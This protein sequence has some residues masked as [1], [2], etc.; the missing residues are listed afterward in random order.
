[1]LSLF[2]NPAK[3]EALQQPQPPRV[4]NP[5]RAAESSNL[6]FPLA[7]QPLHSGSILSITPRYW[8]FPLCSFRPE[9]IP[10]SQ[11]SSNKLASLFGKGRQQKGVEKE[12]EG[13]V[14]KQTT[15]EPVSVYLRFVL[16]ADHRALAK[17]RSQTQVLLL[18]E[19]G[20]SCLWPGKQAVKL[21]IPE[22]ATR[23]LSENLSLVM[24]VFQQGLDAKKDTMFA[25]GVVHH[26]MEHLQKAK[27]PR[28]LVLPM[29]STS[30]LIGNSNRSTTSKRMRNNDDQEIRFEA[31]IRLAYLPFAP[32][33][34]CRITDV[35]RETNKRISDKAKHGGLGKKVVNE[36]IAEKKAE[37]KN[38]RVEKVDDDKTDEGSFPLKTSPGTESEGLIG[39][40]QQWQ[41][42]EQEEEEE[43]EEEEAYE[44][45][46]KEGASVSSTSLNPHLDLAASLMEQI[47]QEQMSD[48]P[49]V[50]MPEEEVVR[51]LEQ[52]EEYNFVEAPARVE[53][54][55]PGFRT[56]LFELAL[57]AKMVAHSKAATSTEHGHGGR[58]TA[59]AVLREKRPGEK[60]Q[61]PVVEERRRR[62]L[63]S[64][65]A[66][67]RR[68]ARLARINKL[69]A[70]LE[71][72]PT[73][74]KN[75]DCRRGQRE[76][77]LN[78]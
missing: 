42:D 24:E 2:R 14:A 64:A 17:A 18:G 55:A 11:V 72:L 38:E 19:D 43:E 78:N 15:R 76:R 26:F 52:E 7:S 22:T 58:T 70:D 66:S 60:L 67:A 75:G 68:K 23:F 74:L 1:M 77:M 16:V 29:V 56:P 46:A 41:H 73:T 48:A 32:L 25:R 39:V 49:P 9:S 47:R 45:L 31:C 27:S 34:H 10:T 62:I 61:V 51:S 40:R 33:G 50:L 6:N 54:A 59:A 21:A 69:L 4:H 36:Q 3:K 53:V 20:A 57:Q 13:D 8:S 44:I 65:T 28:I 12:K 37:G 71:A 5:Q 30:P 35:K 63:K